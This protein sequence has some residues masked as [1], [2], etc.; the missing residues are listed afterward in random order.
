VSCRTGP[1]RVA[2]S[3]RDV[4]T[5]LGLS[6]GF[7]PLVGRREIFLLDAQAYVQI[8]LVAGVGV[9]VVG[10]AAVELVALAEFATDEEADRD[11]SEAG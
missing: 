5:G 1:L 3:L 6:E 2:R 11:G 9:E 7:G 8:L 10:G 4:C